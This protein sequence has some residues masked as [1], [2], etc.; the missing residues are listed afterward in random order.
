MRLETTYLLIMLFEI[1]Y[2]YFT[3]SLKKKLELISIDGICKS[4]YTF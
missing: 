3:V 4:T 2:I 1:R